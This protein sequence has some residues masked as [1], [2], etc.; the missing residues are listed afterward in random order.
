MG[1]LNLGQ[2]CFLNV[3]LQSF[4]ANP[5][6]RSYFLSDMHNH[7]TCKNKEC[8]CCEVDK[9]F[10]EVSCSHVLFACHVVMGRIAV[11]RPD[12]PIWPDKSPRNNLESFIRTCRLRPAGCTRVFHLGV[13]PVAQDSVW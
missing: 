7:K 1:L 3:I 5:L 13:E 11:L 6:L 8:M 10:I 12:H 9:L 2:T 4:L